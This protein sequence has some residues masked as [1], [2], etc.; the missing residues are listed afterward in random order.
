ML[1][2]LYGGVNMINAD[3]LVIG[4]SA[5]GILTATTSRRRI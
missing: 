4:G 3:I 2:I 5:G 1:I